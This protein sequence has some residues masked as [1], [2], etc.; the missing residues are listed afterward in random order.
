[1]EETNAALEI[2]EENQDSEVINQINDFQTESLE[3]FD[4][5]LTI[6]EDESIVDVIEDAIN[7]IQEEQLELQNSLEEVV[8]DETT[9]A[10]SPSD[11]EGVLD[12]LL[13]SQ[14]DETAIEAVETAKSRE[15]GQPE[16][17]DVKIPAPA[18]G[19]GNR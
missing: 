2:A 15:V 10:V 16:I 12:V 7:Q 14:A 11:S 17:P 4:E 9:E 3:T 19:N 6:I 1:L 5:A 13:S 8:V 18:T